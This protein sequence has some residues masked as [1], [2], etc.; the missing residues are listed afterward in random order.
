MGLHGRVGFMILV[1]FGLLGTCSNAVRGIQS[2]APLV[3]I[4]MSVISWSVLRIVWEGVEAVT[5]LQAIAR[6][7][8]EQKKPEDKKEGGGPPG[9]A[10]P[11]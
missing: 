10:S 2:P 11:A 4:I 7:Q 1:C 5:I 9:P 8:D 6:H 3:I